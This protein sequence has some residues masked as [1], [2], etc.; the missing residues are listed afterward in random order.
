MLQEAKRRDG[1]RIALKADQT[2]DMQLVCI[3]DFRL[4]GEGER[5]GS[6]NTQACVVGNVYWLVMVYNILT[7]QSKILSRV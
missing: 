6:A 1:S 2:R 5:H 3:L 4:F 7:L